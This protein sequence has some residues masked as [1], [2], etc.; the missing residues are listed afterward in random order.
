MYNG[1]KVLAILLAVACVLTLAACGKEEVQEEVPQTPVLP[2]EPSDSVTVPQKEEEPVSMEEEN[3]NVVTIQ[4]PFG[5]ICYQEQWSEHM[6]V[7]QQHDAEE[8]TVSFAV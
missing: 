7:T 6:R 1:R 5:D 2:A 3:L 8:L 4:T